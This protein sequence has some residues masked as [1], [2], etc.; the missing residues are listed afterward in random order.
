MLHT[1]ADRK[2]IFFR[3]NI[4]L[5]QKPEII[6]RFQREVNEVNKTLGEIEKIKRFRLVREEWNSNTGELSPTLKLRR[7]YIEIKYD[8]I[9]E[10][11]YGHTYKKGELKPNPTSTVDFGSILP[12]K[13][14]M[15]TLQKVKDIVKNQ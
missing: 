14:I 11:I 1:W 12:T 3:D 13:Q 7:K 9:L 4:E 15:D 6:A 5:I 8:T 2:K 10:E